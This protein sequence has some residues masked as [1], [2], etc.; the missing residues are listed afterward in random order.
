MAVSFVC[1]C[2]YMRISKRVCV[3]VCVCVYVCVCVSDQC[4]RLSVSVC[5]CARSCVKAGNGGRW[6]NVYL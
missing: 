6:A 5:A 2:A 1:V 4:T 3:C